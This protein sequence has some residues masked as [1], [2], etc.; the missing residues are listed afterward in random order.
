MIEILM[1]LSKLMII[2]KEWKPNDSGVQYQI[3]LKNA[4]ISHHFSQLI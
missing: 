2:Q 3:I 1:H 4:Q